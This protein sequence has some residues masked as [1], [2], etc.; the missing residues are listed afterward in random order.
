MTLEREQAGSWTATLSR[1]VRLHRRAQAPGAAR[2]VG[3]AAARAADSIAS[4]RTDEID[5]V[6]AHLL[7]TKTLDDARVARA[8]ARTAP[9]VK[10]R[11]RLRV[12]RELACDGHRQR[13]GRS[14]ALAEV[15]AESTNA[16]SSRK[17]SR[18]RCAA[19]RRIANAAEHARLYQYLMRQGFTPAGIVAALRR[20]R[21]PRRTRLR[22]DNASR[23][24]AV[25]TGYN[26]Q[27]LSR[28]IRSSF[29]EYF[30]Q[31]GHTIV[32]S[33]SLVPHDDPTLLFT[34]AGMNQFKDAFLGQG[35]AGL[36]ARDDVAEVHAGQRKAQ[37][38]R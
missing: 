2:A 6:V 12:M 27:M 10:G 8:Y 17:R 7:E 14:E 26:R 33:S 21:R 35:K 22:V 1:N 9:K 34:N 20:S 23:R 4:I 11:G 15:F 25:T 16:R 28:E 5:R 24:A 38:S 36:H 3:A 30:Q 31:N 37:R 29:L 19:G 32:P 13:D 18:R